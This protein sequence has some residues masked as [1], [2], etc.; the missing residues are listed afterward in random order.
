MRRA[1]PP[2]TPP[3]NIPQIKSPTNLQQILTGGKIRIFHF[4]SIN[5]WSKDPYTLLLTGVKASTTTSIYK[6]RQK[7]DPKSFKRTK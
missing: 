2:P 6:S 1:S 4:L 5:H 3:P 7:K